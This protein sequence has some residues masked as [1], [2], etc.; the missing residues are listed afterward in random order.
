MGQGR[1]RRSGDHDREDASPRRKSVLL[2]L[3]GLPGGRLF[4][5]LLLLGVPLVVLVDLEE[6]ARLQ[7]PTGI[8][9]Q[10]AQHNTRRLLP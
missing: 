9:A 6:A 5:L 2:L 4:G 10:H 1:G 7:G 3:L 8:A